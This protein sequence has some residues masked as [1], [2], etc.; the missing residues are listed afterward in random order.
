MSSS[1]TQASHVA[2]PNLDPVSAKSENLSI[3]PQKKI[4]DLHALIQ[5]AGV[6]MLTTRAA[7][8]ELHS[9]AMVATT[10]KTATQL[11]LVFIAN[12][13]S[14]KFDEL[15]NDSHVNVSYCHTP[16]TSWA[17]F[18]GKAT[19]SQDKAK[20]KEHWSSSAAAYFGNL[21]DGIHKG[22]HDDPRVSIIEVIPDEIRYWV[23]TQSNITRA[24]TEVVTSAVGS[25]T[26]P[27]E[28]RTITKQEIQLVEG[29]H[30]K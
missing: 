7:D 17:S 15:S 20:I 24:I 25:Y 23:A 13:V 30:T 3:T 18:S 6:A 21:N 26:S 28:L 10:P 11:R 29:L 19:V 27:G 2:N 8:G 14:H 5:K 9:R 1:T 16:T 12:N 4:E 22:D